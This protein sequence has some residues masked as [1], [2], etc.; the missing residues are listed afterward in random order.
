MIEN[1]PPPGVGTHRDRV[2]DDYGVHPL[3][4]GLFIFGA[5]FL[6]L[7]LNGPGPPGFMITVP[8]VMLAY[9][10]VDIFDTLIKA[11]QDLPKGPRK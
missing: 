5:V 2:D 10:I 7:M 11:I 1:G 9:S 8:C 3:S 4:Q 6:G